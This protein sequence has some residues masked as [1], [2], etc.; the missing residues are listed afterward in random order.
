[1]TPRASVIQDAADLEDIESDVR[2]YEFCILYPYPIQ[3][4]EAQELMKSLEEIFA[5][6]QGKVVMKDLWG[7]RGLAYKIGGYA[8]GNFAIL[9]VELDP[10][11]L[12][13]IDRML[14]I[15]KGVL[16]HMIVKPPKNYQPVSYA[17]KFVQWQ[18]DKKLEGER[19]EREREEKLQRQV[20][21]KAKR[22]AKPAKKAEAPT[23]V[24]PAMTEEAI[25]KE[26]EKL[27]SGE[28]LKI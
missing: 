10:S 26:L 23:E 12:K 9:Y 7:Q 14:R 22:T 19:A 8:E 21:E 3:P 11:K 17:E 25:S 28:D 2:L 24:K 18:E 20:V 16:R 15:Q 6:A 5:E 1:M 4:K 13:E 27:I